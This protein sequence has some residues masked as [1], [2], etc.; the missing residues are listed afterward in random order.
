MNATRPLLLAID[1]VEENLELLDDYLCKEYDVQFALSGAEGLLLAR[2]KQP[3]LILLD[4]MMPGMDGYEVCAALKSEPILCDIPVIFLTAKESLDSESNAFAAGAVDFVHKPIN[5]VVLRAR[6]L[7][8]IRLK[9]Y[10]DELRTLAT[11]DFLTGLANR[12]MLDERLEIEW[13]RAMRGRQP[14]SLLMIDIDYFKL[15]NDH[16]GHPEGDQC[17]RQV[18]S[19]IASGACRAGEFVA[20]YGGEEF[21]VLLAEMAAKQAFAVAEGIRSRV[22]AL[23]LPHSYSPVGN[24]VTVS[25]GVADAWPTHES[26]QTM[27]EDLEEGA[28]IVRAANRLLIDA[29]QALYAAKQSGRNQVVVNVGAF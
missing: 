5:P 20:R 18:A 8:H 25:I 24:E 11:I 19:A 17:L 10:I 6:V 14:L 15:Y 7:T 1:D 21:V 22:A 12:R 26:M 9:R 3:D 23:H 13:R 27:P 2:R 28:R 29:D 16:Y 4:V